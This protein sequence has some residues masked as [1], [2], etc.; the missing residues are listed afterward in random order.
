MTESAAPDSPLFSKVPVVTEPKK[1]PVI[2]VGLPRSG[3]SFLSHVLSTLDD[4]YVFDDLHF[5]RE[6]RAVKAD[7]PLTSEQLDRLVFFLGWQVRAR[8]KFEEH[9]SKPRC[10]LEDVD[11]MCAAVL[12]TFRERPVVWH[13]LME[14]W[15]MRLALHHGKTRWG[16][17]TPQDF[18]H[19]RELHGLFPGARFLFIMR[20][21]R[22][23]MA[24]IKYVPPQDGARGQYH[25]CIYASYWKMAYGAFRQL[26]S[27]GDIPILMVRFESLVADPDGQA[28]A[29]AEF[30]GATL[31]RSVPV[32]GSNTSFG[33]GKRRDLTPTEKWM[34]ERIAGPVM[35]S[36]GYEVEHPRPRLRDVPDLLFTT[37]RF[38]GYQSSR[39]IREPSA[40][41]S[42]TAFLRRLIR[43]T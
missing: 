12:E 34:C 30:L 40:R 8:I 21:P 33:G 22:R 17:K 37:A 35:E 28:R 14:E 9:F 3:S 24:S 10:T 26:E 1:P 18:M 2:I 39:L 16:Y 19:V 25:P 29:I 13:E 42:V 4:W 38:A 41:V 6:A 7:G 32:R 36:A 11:R 31:T 15:M 43:R 23:M 20:D 27:A 5:Y